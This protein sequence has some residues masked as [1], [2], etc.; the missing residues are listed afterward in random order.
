ML[1][2]FSVAMILTIFFR[3]G[4]RLFF[5]GLFLANGS[6]LIWI[7]HRFPAWVRPYATPEARLPDFLAGFAVS[8]LACVLMLWV[9]LE[10]HN[11]ERQRTELRGTGPNQRV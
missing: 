5:L 1:F 8:T 6:A 2:L 9:L 3:G 11:A 4:E 7:H 10:S